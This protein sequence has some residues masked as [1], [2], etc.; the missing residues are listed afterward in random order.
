MV[1]KGGRAHEDMSVTVGFDPAFDFGQFGICDQFLP[2]PQIKGGLLLL[3]K[4]FDR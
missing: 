1:G 2:T 3:G 4:E